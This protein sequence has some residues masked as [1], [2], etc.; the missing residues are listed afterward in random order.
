MGIHSNFDAVL[1]NTAERFRTGSDSRCLL[2]SAEIA[3][4][5]LDMKK[6]RFTLFAALFVSA[7]FVFLSAGD[8]PQKEYIDKYASLAVAEMYRSGVPAS[9]TLAQGMLES[10]NGLAALAAEGN[11]HF[12]IKCHTDWTGKSMK[13]DDD[14]KGEC[15]RVYDDAYESFKDHSDFLRYRPRYQFLFDYDITDYKAWANGLKKAGYAT[16][17]QYASKLIRIIE[18]NSLAQYDTKT[19][20][21]M[22]VAVVETTDGDVVVEDSKEVELPKEAKSGRKVKVK[23]VRKASRKASAEL[24]I[25]DIPESPTVLAEPRAAANE[26]MVYSL[27]RKVYEQNGVPF[28]YSNNGDTYDSIASEYHLFRKEILK[29][30]DLSSSEELA[31]GT[32]VY[33]QAKKNQTKRGLDK[34]IVE[35]D[36]ESLRDI[37]QQY[38]VKMQSVI[39]M[40]AFSSTHRLREG[41]TIWL[42]R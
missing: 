28:V 1:S 29:F 36:D 6:I 16:D 17:P 3:N 7:V 31:P 9:I 26:G 27:D 30:N 38:G 13:V 24:I 37:C 34:Y 20:A 12:G 5:R 14:K 21:Q 10:R 22:G 25:E 35:K 39:K 19:P 40:N 23:K 32:V 2:N 42:R 15:F 18:E 41:D 4:L 11:N 8:T 33:L